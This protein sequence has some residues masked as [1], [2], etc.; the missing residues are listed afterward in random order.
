VRLYQEI[1]AIA[2]F[3][4]LLYTGALNLR[5]RPVLLLIGGIALMARETFLIYLF[6][7]TLL[8]WKVVLSSRAY[9]LSFLFLWAIPVLWLLAIPVGY[10]AHDGRLPAFPVEWPLMINK[11]EGPAVSQVSTSL[12]SLWASLWNSRAVYL[13]AAIVLAWV[14]NRLGGKRGDR[15]YIGESEEF[16]SRFQVFS[17]LSLGFAYAAIV[18]F[19]PWAVSF[20]N[21]RMAAPL[22]EQLFIWTLIVMAATLSCRGVF[23]VIAGTIL[24]AGLVLAIEPR[25][26]AWV[27]QESPYTKTIYP[28]L[29][30]LLD[31]SSP[32]ARPLVCFGAEG[33]FL[34]MRR[35]VAPTLYAQRRFLARGIDTIPEDCS[36]L[37]SRPASVPPNVGNFV[38][39]RE[40]RMDGDSYVVYRRRD[41]P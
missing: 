1:V 41:S 5:K 3:Y 11:A 32:N 13:L 35:F 29:E 4:V 37:I 17:L 9:R 40:F 26:R 7:L 6:S 16:R 39:L 10:L 22:I 2:L 21:P 12:R 33:V 36:V 31:E 20:G 14:V 24:M 23:R 19:D 27:P 34:T 38:R 30:R 8:N 18:L 28:E 25:I 15:A